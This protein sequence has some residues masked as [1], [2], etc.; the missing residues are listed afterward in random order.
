MVDLKFRLEGFD[1]QDPAEFSFEDGPQTDGM[2]G[3]GK[4]GQGIE[5]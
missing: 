5:R 3:F 2:A 1:L 4:D